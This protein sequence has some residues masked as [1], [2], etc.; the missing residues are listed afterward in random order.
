MHGL[1]KASCAWCRPFFNEAAAEL[2]FHYKVLANVTE[3]QAE[4]GTVDSYI[5]RNGNV[6]ALP[7][8]VPGSTAFYNARCSTSRS[9][10]PPCR[11][12][13][14]GQ[15]W[16]LSAFHDVLVL[17]GSNVLG[18]RYAPCISSSDP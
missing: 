12:S 5:D 6:T 14:S 13:C 11:T 1:I 15:P 16:Q 7:Y 17:L 4:G 18:C 2:S 10:A 8:I 9:F 3:L